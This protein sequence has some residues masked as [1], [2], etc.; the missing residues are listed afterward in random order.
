MSAKGLTVKLI[1][2]PPGG[3]EILSPDLLLMFPG[4]DIDSQYNLQML[5]PSI[6]R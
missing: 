6:K 1:D 3:S 4:E 2:D 5:A